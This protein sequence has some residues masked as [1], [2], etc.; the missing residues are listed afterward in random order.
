[1]RSQWRLYP[2]F[3]CGLVYEM[4]LRRRP[5]PIRLRLQNRRRCSCFLI[6]PTAGTHFSGKSFQTVTNS[7]T[8]TTIGRRLSGFEIDEYFICSYLQPVCSHSVQD[9][10]HE[11]F[12]R[13]TVSNCLQINLVRLYVKN[14]QCCRAIPQSAFMLCMSSL[15]PSVYFDVRCLNWR[16]L[17]SS[18]FMAFCYEK[19]GK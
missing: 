3:L 8:N 7:K 9:R 19:S 1:M 13:T 4:K 17:E 12:V 16:A 6:I 15:H 5:Q 14:I 11:T 2:D 18:N 10:R